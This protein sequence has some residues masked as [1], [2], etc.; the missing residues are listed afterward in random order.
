M[1]QYI[2]NDSIGQADKVLTAIEGMVDKLPAQ[3][4][5]HAP[6]KYRKNNDSTYRAFTKYHCRVAYRILK[7]EIRIVQVRHTSRKPHYY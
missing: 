3:P 1:Y 6:D 4:T 5:K 2:A 7:S